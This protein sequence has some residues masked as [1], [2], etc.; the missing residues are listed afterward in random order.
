MPPSSPLVAG[1]DLGGTNMQIGIVDEVGTI[2]ARKK[3]KTRSDKGSDAVLDRIIEGVTEACTAAGIS[4][5]DLAAVGIGAPGAI[6][7]DAGVVI[8]APNLGWNRFPLA[9]TLSSALADRPIMLDN[10]VNVAIV[11]EHQ[12]GAGRGCDDVL[13][14]WIGTGIGGG[15]ILG[16][17]LYHGALGTAGEIG[18][19]I[20]FPTAAI[21]QRTL[22][23]SCSRKHVVDRMRHLV[24]DGHPT[25]LAQL[26]DSSARIGAKLVAEAYDKG[27]ELTVT[28]IDEITTLLGS[29]IGSV[30]TLLSLPRVI[31][32]GGLTE[33][34]GQPF[35]DRVATHVREVVFPKSLSSV[36][37]VP[38]QLEDDAGLLGAAFMAQQAH[39]TH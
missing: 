18:Q 5:A 8:E 20:L 9:R 29:S 6:D 1:I 15:L 34:L 14:V 21:G 4:P 3:R 37:I 30:I 33:A 10:D 36:K 13:G 16:G 25:L 39:C 17:K 28:V 24:E 12:F 31:L 27:D 26:T 32:G 35:V 19:M 22:E 23:Q 7:H 38:T 11:G 2:V